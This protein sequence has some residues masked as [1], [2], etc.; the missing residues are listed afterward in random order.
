M[1]LYYDV[2]IWKNKTKIKSRD[3]NF[4]LGYGLMVA[5]FFQNAVPISK[6]GPKYE[7]AY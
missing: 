7:L 6:L 4:L 1:T 2:V 3:P 5:I